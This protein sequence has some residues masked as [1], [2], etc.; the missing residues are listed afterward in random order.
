MRFFSARPV[1]AQPGPPLNAGTLAEVVLVPD[2][3]TRAARMGLFFFAQRV[4][5]VGASGRLASLRDYL[6]FPLVFQ[7]LER[8]GIRRPSTFQATATAAA[9]LGTTFDNEDTPVALTQFQAAF[10]IVERAARTKALPSDRA[11]DLLEGLS[12]LPLD[13]G[14]Y[15]GQVANWVSKALIPSL[16]LPQAPTPASGAWREAIILRALAGMPATGKPPVQV[17]EWEGASYEYDPATAEFKRLQRMREKQ[18]GNNLDAVLDLAAFL[19]R[20]PAITDAPGESAQLLKLTERLTEPPVRPDEKAIGIKPQVTDLA[21]RAQSVARNPRDLPAWRQRVKVALEPIVDALVAHTLRSILYAA[22]LGDPDGELLMNGDLA[23]RHNLRLLV[24]GSPDARQAPAW[25]VPEEV[26]GGGSNRHVRGS[27]LALDLAMWKMALTAPSNEPPQGVHPL[28]EPNPK[29]F[30]WSGVLFD[31]YSAEAGQPGKVAEA[32]RAGRQR[33]QQAMGDA[34]ALEA[35]AREAGL[36]EWAQNTIAWTLETKRESAVTLF[37][38]RN[39]LT[40]GLGQVTGLSQATLDAW[41]ASE[42]P[43]TGCLLLRQPSRLPP[44]DY[45]GRPRAGFLSS[46]SSDMTLRVAEWLVATKLPPQMARDI[47]PVAYQ[48]LRDAGPVAHWEDAHS[49]RNYIVGYPEQRF[50]QVVGDAVAA[51]AYRL[52]DAAPLRQ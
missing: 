35:L 5:P 6:R 45:Q 27:L 36:P 13:R 43:V 39:L 28:V 40:L 3:E 44:D 29:N 12:S 24:S 41:G 50:Q 11:A 15:K 10:S 47:L 31:P 42:I 21:S 9:N 37:G 30:G 8:A 23:H 25:T 1:A 26:P 33:V 52:A 34:A 46:R 14:R 20:V 7:V 4:F 49:V 2:E 38:P 48:D 32:L 18:G 17:F 51:G 19:E 22:Y 16:A